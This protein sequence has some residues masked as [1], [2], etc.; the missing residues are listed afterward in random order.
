[1]PA[2]PAK[3][4]AVPAKKKAT[5]KKAAK[6]TSRRSANSTSTR[7]RPRWVDR[8]LDELEARGTVTH[9]CK[10]A[11]IDRKTPYN[12]REKD[13][14]FAAAWDERVDRVTDRLEASLLERAIDG[15]L[16]PVYHAGKVV[17][18]TR[19]FD[20][21]LA[22]RLLR[23]RRPTPYNLASG[24]QGDDGEDAVEQAAAK[25]REFLAITAQ[26]SGS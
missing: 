5:K 3:E 10:A 14:E 9:A 20:N 17:G 13:E 4:S 21:G 26:V 8:F 25:I 16:R 15:W 2:V 24:V 6:K 19:E 12:R 18:A 22:W 11:G 7:T 1:M 23:A